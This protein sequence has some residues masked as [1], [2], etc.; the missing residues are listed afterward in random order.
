MPGESAHADALALLARLNG[1]LDD[2]AVRG[3]RAVGADETA[4]LGSHREALA[5][6][7]AAHLAEALGQLL[8]DLRS[9]R[10]EAARSLL[11]TRASVR[12]FERLLSLR[13]VIGDLTDGLADA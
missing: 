8:A 13:M 6:M 12:V 1:L 3:L 9:G 10:R 2:L 4:R 11:G 5:E 7:G